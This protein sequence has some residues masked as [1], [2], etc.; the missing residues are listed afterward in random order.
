MIWK[1]LLAIGLNFVLF[2][3]GPKLMERN[4]L[5][6]PLT[7]RAWI[8]L[9]VAAVMVSFKTIFG[10]I[11]SGNFFYHKHGYDFCIAAL[12]ASMSGLTIQLLEPT[13]SLFPGLASVPLAGLITFF[14]KDPYTL[15]VS[16]LGFFF[17][18][19]LFSTVITARI[20]RSITHENPWLP[21]LLAGL[22]FAFG[23]AILGLY[24]LL[25]ISKGQA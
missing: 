16:Y 7:D 24:I 6:P 8:V 21:D 20:S 19:S 15:S 17:I 23:T 4:G 9:F 5:L 2:L 3:A 22:N 13:K 1:L 14:S 12:G 25:L 11:A 18:I 10:D